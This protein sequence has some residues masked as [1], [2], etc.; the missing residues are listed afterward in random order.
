MNPDG[1][2][3]VLHRIHLPSGSRVQCDAGYDFG[4]SV[5]LASSLQFDSTAMG[6][7]MHG[8]SKMLRDTRG[9]VLTE[10]VAVVGLVALGFVATMVAMGPKLVEA[11]QK[12][13]NMV[14]SPFP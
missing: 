7:T 9:A 4:A 6:D 10:Y 2:L 11:Y 14:A 8:V 12:T 5:G 3:S 13:R 1:C